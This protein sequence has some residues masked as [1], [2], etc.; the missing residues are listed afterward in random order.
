MVPRMPTL[1]TQIQELASSFATA[2]LAALRDASIE[3]L[4]S[5]NAASGLPSV[6]MKRGPGRPRKT[7]IAPAVTS[8]KPAAAPPKK[9]ARLARR[10]PSDIEHVI[11]LLVA[12]L[13]KHKAGL[14][15]EQ[16][17]KT[18]KLSKAEIVG[19]LAQGLAMGRLKKTGER[20]ATT[21]FAA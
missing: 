12:T 18:L 16:L 8:L 9:G 19:P 4:L 5:D 15:S 14:R 13:G 20:R 21:Y 17:Q 10:S 3:D 2:V 11:G 6:P 1:Q 7:A